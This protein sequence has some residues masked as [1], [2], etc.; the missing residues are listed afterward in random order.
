MSQ[1]E[2]D[3]A[4]NTSV[5]AAEDMTAVTRSNDFSMSNRDAKLEPMTSAFVGSVGSAE[6]EDQGLIGEVKTDAEI[7]EQVN[8]LESD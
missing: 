6:A 2:K 1:Y 5:V 8:I 7:R 4:A 3:K